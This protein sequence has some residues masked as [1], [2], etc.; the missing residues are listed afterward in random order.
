MFATKV[1]LSCRRLRST[2]HLRKPPLK[3]PHT[4]AKQ[5]V[6]FVSV[7]VLRNK[8]KKLEQTQKI[9]PKKNLHFVLPLSKM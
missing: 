7:T 8:K 4:K 1:F 9:N 3:T 6:V 2:K 5:A